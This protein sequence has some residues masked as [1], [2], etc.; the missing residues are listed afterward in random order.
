MHV[1]FRSP[2]SPAEAN[3]NYGACKQLCFRANKCGKDDRIVDPP[4]LAEKRATWL[5][6]TCGPDCS[7][8]P[9]PEPSAAEWGKL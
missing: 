4:E 2:P 5:Q 3:K 8:Y 9:C 6:N 7:V 1:R